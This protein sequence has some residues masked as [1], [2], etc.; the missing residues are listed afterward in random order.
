[1]EE[2]A[3]L[4]A[5]DRMMKLHGSGAMTAANLKADGMLNRGNIEGYYAWN[6]ITA[7]INDRGRASKPD[8]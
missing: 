8:V 2:V 4:E 3:I 6:R 7:V 5:A 1:M